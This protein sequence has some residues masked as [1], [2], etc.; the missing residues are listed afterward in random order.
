MRRNAT[1]SSVPATRIASSAPTST[2][3][4]RLARAINSAGSPSGQSCSRQLTSKLTSPVMPG[5]S[6]SNRRI[7]DRQVSDRAGVMPL[8]CTTDARPNADRTA[9]ESRNPGSIAEAAEPALLYL[10]TLRG[11]PTSS[12]AVTFE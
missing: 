9:A 8:Q 12:G 2:M 5:R 1:G 6:V 10:L 3:S 11:S 4:A 7:M